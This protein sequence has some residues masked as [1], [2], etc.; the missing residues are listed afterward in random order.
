M[1]FIPV[2]PKRT[3]LQSIPITTEMPGV[4][5]R[6]KDF[7]AGAL[8]VFGILFTGSEGP[9]FPWPNLLGLAMLAGFAR[10]AGA[11]GRNRR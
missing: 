3:L 7:F 9:L 8:L 1:I 4:K 2:R 10:L 6:L 5:A 11:F